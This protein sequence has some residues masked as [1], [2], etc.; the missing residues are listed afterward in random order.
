M[1]GWPP[2]AGTK[3]Q[4]RF[5]PGNLVLSRSVSTGDPDS[6]SRNRAGVM[7]SVNLAICACSTAPAPGMRC[8]VQRGL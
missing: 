3:H 1:D 2:T 7:L 4:Q 5:Q 6:A 8:S